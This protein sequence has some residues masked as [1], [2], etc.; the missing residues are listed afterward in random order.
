MNTMLKQQELLQL[1]LKQ[2]NAS[3][4]KKPLGNLIICKHRG[5]NQYY[6]RTSP[7]ERKGVYLSK[8]KERN[9]IRALAQKDYDQKFIL[10]AKKLAHNN[11]RL[12]KWNAER[13]I[14]FFYLEL[15]QVY[16]DLSPARQQLVTPYVPPDDMFIKAWKAQEYQGNLFSFNP[17]QEIF[18]LNKERVR[19]KSEKI[20]ADKLWTD[21]IPYRYE[22]PLMT[23][24][25]GRIYPDFTLLDIWNRVEVIFEHFGRLLYTNLP[26][27]L[28]KS[29]QVEVINSEA[30][31]FSE[32]SNALLNAYRWKFSSS[33]ISLYNLVGGSIFRN[34]L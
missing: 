31:A 14:H 29:V 6:H 33:R 9:L 13:E 20:I 27:Y 24:A 3:L 28:R 7:S 2:A 10:A 5:Q 8:K 16:L 32:F 23:H 25:L 22:Y 15:A 21:G 18:T 12:I 26:A 30:V 1:Y 4:V 17:D 11:D 19:S 34:L